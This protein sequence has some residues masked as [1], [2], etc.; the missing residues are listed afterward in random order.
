M[1]GDFRCNAVSTHNVIIPL[2]NDILLGRGGGN[3][4]HSGNER[5]LK[6]VRN[7]ACDYEAAKRE[8]KSVIS[9]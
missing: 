1:L 7:R 9:R 6:L 3:Y 2:E 4:R 8:Q 5:L